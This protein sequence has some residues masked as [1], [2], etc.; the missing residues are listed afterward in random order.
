MLYIPAFCLAL[1]AIIFW[2]IFVQRSL[3]VI[4]ENTRNAM[5]QIGVLISSQWEVLTSIL[6]STEWCAAHECETITET[7]KTR[8]MITKDSSL[9]DVRKQEMFLADVK[10]KIVKF[11]ESSAEL[12]EDCRYIKTMKAVH[13][14]ENMVRTSMLIYNDS[15]SKLNHAIHM[16][17]ASIIAG[18]LGFSHRGY[19]ESDES[20]DY[21]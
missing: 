15:A 19:F 2:I 12:R 8:H 9:D 13:Q 11:A 20:R 18:I 21:T 10:T 14:Y 3:V 17:P 1:V 16:F 6:D 7:M 4:D 5:L